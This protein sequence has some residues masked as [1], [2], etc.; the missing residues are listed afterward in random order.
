MI[1][2]LAREYEGK[3][4]AVRYVEK[5]MVNKILPFLCS[6]FS[7]IAPSGQQARYISISIEMPCMAYRW[8]APQGCSKQEVRLRRGAL[9]SRS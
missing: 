6:I 9:R 5:E 7:C 3:G 2:L 1:P 4:A 8:Q